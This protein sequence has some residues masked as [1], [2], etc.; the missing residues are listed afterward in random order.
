MARGIPGYQ[1]LDLNAIWRATG[2]LTV[3]LEGESL[4]HSSHVEIG[5]PQERSAIERSV[6]GRLTWDF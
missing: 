4:L 3:S 1:E 2:H 6:F 5:G